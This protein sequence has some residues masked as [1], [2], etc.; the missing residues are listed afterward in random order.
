MDSCTQEGKAGEAKPGKIFFFNLTMGI[1][2][3][4]YMHAMLRMGCLGLVL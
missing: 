4:L 2:Q 3:E 1:Q